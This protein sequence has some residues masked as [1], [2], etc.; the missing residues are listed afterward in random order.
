MTNLNISPFLTLDRPEIN[1]L[2]GVW[3]NF[4]AL[5]LKYMITWYIFIYFNVLYINIT[6]YKLWK[7][8]SGTIIWWV[9][10]LINLHLWQCY[11]SD[12]SNKWRYLG[13]ILA[14]YSIMIKDSPIKLY[15]FFLVMARPIQRA[16]WPF[17]KKWPPSLVMCAVRSPFRNFRSP[18]SFKTAASTD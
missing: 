15:I 8:V 13:H 14:D 11:I 7:Q 16:L 2:I 1:L 10:T 3:A 12:L 6:L 4:A 9:M 5:F 17:W 18:S